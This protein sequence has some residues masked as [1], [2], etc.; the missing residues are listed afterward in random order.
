MRKLSKD[1]RPRLGGPFPFRTDKPVYR[2]GDLLIGMAGT[3]WFAY[4]ASGEKVS[5]AWSLRQLKHQLRAS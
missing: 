5:F 2:D 1:E 4:T 3:A